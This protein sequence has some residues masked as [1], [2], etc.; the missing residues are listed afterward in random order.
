M[1]AIE[2]I[3]CRAAVAWAAKEPLKIENIEVQPPNNGEV[4]IKVGFD[5][6]RSQV[7]LL[8][9][10]RRAYDNKLFFKKRPLCF[11]RVGLELIG[12]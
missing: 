12:L 10:E 7:C 8:W 3:K 1:R 11:Q 2:V 5:T 4:R 9:S 6:A